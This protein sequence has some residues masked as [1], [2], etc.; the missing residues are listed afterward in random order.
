MLFGTDNGDGGNT[1]PITISQMTQSKSRGYCFTINN[2]TGWDDADIDKV[3]EATIYGVYGIEVG[4]EGTR[5]YQGFIRFEHPVS[6]M[7]VKGLL[8]RAHIEQQR[9]SIQEEINCLNLE[10]IPP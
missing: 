9:G 7:R 10:N 5:H 1:S 6:F 8:P 2:P 4:E 3:K